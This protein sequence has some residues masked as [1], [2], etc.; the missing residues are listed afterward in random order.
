M[1]QPLVS[2]DLSQSVFHKGKNLSLDTGNQEPSVLPASF[3][4]V[5]TKISWGQELIILII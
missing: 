5:L 2:K 1:S 3:C 4:L